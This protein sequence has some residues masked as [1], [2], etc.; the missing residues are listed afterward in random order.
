M[1]AER[2]LELDKACSLYAYSVGGMETLQ[3]GCGCDYRA[4]GSAVFKIKFP[5]A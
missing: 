3:A 2:S 1:S 5:H 4:W